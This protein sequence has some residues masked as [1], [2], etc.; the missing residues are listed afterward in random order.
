MTLSVAEA[1]EA[2]KAVLLEEDREQQ[3]KQIS[4]SSL[5]KYSGD[6]SAATFLATFEA[7]AALV[8][9]STEA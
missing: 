3:T 8:G 7:E 5:T 4:I 2:A 1:A 9:I 6:T